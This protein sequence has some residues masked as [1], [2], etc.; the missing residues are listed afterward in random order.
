M[1]LVTALSAVV[2]GSEAYIQHRRGAFSH[3]PMWTP[4]WL[5]P[6][7]TLAAG[8]ALVS[9]WAA[10]KLLPVLSVVLADGVL[11]FAYHIR[12]IRRMP[13]GLSVGRYNS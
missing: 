2:S 5:T 9:E 11:G 13:G 8:A 10:R 3:W 4:V 1:A 12:G 7:T 6:P